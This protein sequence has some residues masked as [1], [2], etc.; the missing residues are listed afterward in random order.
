[1][2][3]LVNASLRYNVHAGPAD[4]VIDPVATVSVA[5][6]IATSRS[7]TAGVNDALAYVVAFVVD[8]VVI[9]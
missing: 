5:A 7:F 1:M 4:P 6:T 2:V 8:A 9:S 3:P